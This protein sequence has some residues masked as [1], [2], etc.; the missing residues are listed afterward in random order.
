MGNEIKT[1]PP[2]PLSPFRIPQL[3]VI[4]TGNPTSGQ[5]GSIPTWFGTSN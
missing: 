5:K 1:D 2:I 4:E 3:F